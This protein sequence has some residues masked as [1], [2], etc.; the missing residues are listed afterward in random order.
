M[1]D[2]R[3]N[4]DE[5]NDNAKFFA[6]DTRVRT[7]TGTVRC[8]AA[9]TPA[10][11]FGTRTMPIP[12]SLT[13]RT[14]S[15]E[16]PLMGELKISKCTLPP[17]GVYLTAFVNRLRKIFCILSLSAMKKF[18]IPARSAREIASYP[19]LSIF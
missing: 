5:W 4:S 8:T 17:S 18:E 2:I 9:I 12:S 1:P 7:H 14:E 15:V 6:D 16:F 19:V 11:N 10:E 3:W 13:T